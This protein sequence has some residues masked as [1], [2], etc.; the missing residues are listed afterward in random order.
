MSDESEESTYVDPLDLMVEARSGR[1]S[2]GRFRDIV[3]RSVS[4]V[5][6]A[7]RLLVC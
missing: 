6:R 4:L 5:W 3:R 7:G 1:K 2:V